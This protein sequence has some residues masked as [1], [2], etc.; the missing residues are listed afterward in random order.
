MS[1]T[2]RINMHTGA[3]FHLI[4]IRFTQSPLDPVSVLLT[5]KGRAWACCLR[6]TFGQ[7][8]LALARGAAGL[9]GQH[10]GVRQSWV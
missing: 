7:L 9:G 5:W 10:T 1:V 8:L 4:P 3:T 2:G 6:K